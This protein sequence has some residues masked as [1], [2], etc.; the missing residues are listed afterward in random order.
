MAAARARET[1]T[2]A[3]EAWF[4]EHRVDA[5]LE[6]TAPCTA[7]LRGHG[8]DSGTSVARPIR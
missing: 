4:A 6:P 2:A 8:Y 1:T 3:W 7:G 5:L